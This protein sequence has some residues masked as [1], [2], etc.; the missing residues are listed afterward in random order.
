[1][2]LKGELF[3]G[4]VINEAEKLTVSIGLAESKMTIL[5]TD[6]LMH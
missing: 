1:M 2:Y 4:V 5:H 6:A 3:F